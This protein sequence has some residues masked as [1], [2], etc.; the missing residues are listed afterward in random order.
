MTTPMLGGCAC[1]AIRYKTT[2]EPILMLHCHCRDCQ[3]ASGG[4]FSA[5]VL[6]PTEAFTLVQGS[7]RF[8]ASPSEAGGQTHRGFCLECGS[9]VQ[10]MTDSQPGIVAIR[11]ASLDDPSWFNPQMN[12][13][14]SDAH[15]WDH[16]NPAL[17]KF[18]KYPS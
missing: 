5:F 11:A 15:P 16:I 14:A 10:V 3:R 9:P 8:H 17:P 4:P 18:E 13:W 6:V 1:G 2:A 12:V 7:L